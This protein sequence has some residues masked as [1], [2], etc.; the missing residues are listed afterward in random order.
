MPID[1]DKVVGTTL[2]PTASAWEPK[3]VML[4]HLGLGAGVPATDEGELEY[5]YEGK[6][7]VLPSFAVVPVFG[8][9]ASV[10]ITDGIQI[11]PMMVL[12][13]EQEITLHKPLPTSAKVSSTATITDV[14]DKGKGA[15]IVV[16]VETSD[17]GS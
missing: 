13:G 17:D 3:D 4:Y 7:K 12:H 5:C 6:L 2:P 8:A 15:A 9:I 11:N 10:I 16:R 14:F 1:I